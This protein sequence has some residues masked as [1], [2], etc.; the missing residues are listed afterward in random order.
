MLCLSGTVIVLGLLVLL[1]IA[2][3]WLSVAMLRRGELYGRLKPEGR[4]R[5]WVLFCLL[6]LLVVFVIWF[7]VWIAWPGALISRFLTLLFT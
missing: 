6:T 5:R 7:P 3:V 1:G 4:P 2:A